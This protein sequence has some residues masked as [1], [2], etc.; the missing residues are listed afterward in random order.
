[1]AA[2]LPVP[3][4]RVSDLLTSQRLVRQIQNDQLDL[5]R[6]QTQLSTGRRVISPS[7]DAP[8]AL[9]AMNI[10]RIL[11]RKTQA[12]TSLRD[13]VGFLNGAW[14]ATGSVSSILNDIKSAALGVN[15][16]INTADER[17]A[18][19]NQIDEAIQALVDTGNTQ[20]RERYLFSGSRS[21]VSPFE[22]NGNY[23][24]YRGNEEALRSYV[25][26]E[27]LF[28]TNV[29]GSEVFGGLSQQVRGSVDLD[30]QLSHETELR[31][32]NGGA[33]VS[34][35]SIEIV[36]I[37]SNNKSTSSNV[38]L[39]SA[40][41]IG[42]VAR[43]LEAGAPEG[44]GIRVEVTATGL[45]LSTGSATEQVLVQE[46]AQGR[47][48]LDLG[49][50]TTTP[51]QNLVGDDITPVLLRTTQLSDL[52]GTKAQATLI[53]GGSNNDLLISTTQNGDRVDPND[54]L[55]DPLNGVTVQ[56]VSGGTK[57]SETALYDPV[58]ATLTV[59]IAAGDSTAEEVAAA[60]NAEASGLFSAQIDARDAASPALA[61]KG[62]IDLSAT[63]VTG[64][65]S[66]ESLDLASGLLIG[67]GGDSVTV[68]ISSAETVEDLLN[69]LNEAELGLRAEINAAGNGINI[70]SRLSGADLTIGEVSGGQTAT[71]IGVRTLT[72]VTQIEDFNRG[73]GVVVGNQTELII[74]L[75]T[76]GVPTT[77]RIDLSGAKTVDDVF[78]EIVTQSGGDVSAQL[79][80]N[81]NG[82][83]LVD[84]TAAD[85]LRV[86]GQVAELLGFFESGD[87]EASS[88]TGTLTATDRHT[89]E[90]DSVFN[91]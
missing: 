28:E 34:H 13:S 30:P 74:E 60:I 66:G 88:G 71:Q 78:A 54:P 72:E 51:Q 62:S 6:I 56:F 15:D 31:D 8:A 61:G 57:G 42:D 23:V 39:S 53:S 47:T 91:T 87:A 37:D 24:E 43:F 50:L 3:T 68:D 22:Y 27:F 16:T 9:R 1:M 17:G 14:E 40:A 75:T 67:N 81:G 90:V 64:G 5:F 25:D 46:V 59:T 41:T 45:T 83:E 65:G 32:L 38:D 79:V 20:F 85:T 35:G 12:Q 2:I 73:V 77:H 10:Q 80:A 33:G 49:I 82:I 52:L 44:S 48:A 70:R 19:I 18:V 26:V 11:E 7:D 4:R 55:S 76:A 29:P 84:N 58:A 69:S 89:L 63:A 36:Y 86:E 21:N